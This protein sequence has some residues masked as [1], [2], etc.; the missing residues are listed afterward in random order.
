[1][2]RKEPKIAE[3]ITEGLLPCPFCRSDDVYVGYESGGVLAGRCMTCGALGPR[4]NYDQ[5][6]RGEIEVDDYNSLYEIDC[7]L[8]DKAF[9]AWNRRFD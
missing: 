5:V 1:M 8:R 6:E 9:E 2:A 4:Y 3:P 7:Q